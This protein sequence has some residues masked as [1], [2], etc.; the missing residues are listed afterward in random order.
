LD[1]AENGQIIEWDEENSRFYHLRQNGHI[2]EEE[3]KKMFRQMLLG[4]E[5]CNKKIRKFRLKY[6]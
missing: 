4:I 5:N 2:E 3:L 1:Y 6:V